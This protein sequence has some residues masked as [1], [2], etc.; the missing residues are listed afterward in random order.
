[1]EP[2]VRRPHRHDLLIAAAGLVGG[3]S[4]WL[5]GLRMQNGRPF[6][7][8]WAGL[9]PLA[10]MAAAELMRCTRPGAA[11]ALATVL[12]AADQ[13]TPGNMA[14]VLMYTDVVYAAV[15]YGSE[16]AARRIPVA[17]LLGSVALALALLPRLRPA[18]AVLVGVL[19]GLVSFVPAITG[20]AARNHRDAAEAARLRAE[21][22]ALLAETDRAQ[23]V[24]EERSRM[25]RELH[26]VVAGHLSAIALHSTAALSIDDPPTS[27]EALSVIRENSVAGLAEMRRLIGLL[28]EGGAPDLPGAAPRLSA[29]DALIERSRAHAASSGLTCVLDDARGGGVLPAPVELA[30]YR[31]VQESL[32]NALKHAAPGAVR[33]RLARPGGLLTVEVTSVSG[34][35]KGFRTPGSGAGLIGMRERAELLGGTIRAGEERAADGTALWRVRAELPVPDDV[36]GHGETTS[37]DM[38]KGR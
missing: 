6:E 27:R 29:L 9:V 2:V 17:S 22:T 23:A 35:R 12:L 14:T 16:A 11:L 34:A 20:A 33:V 28:R 5:L 10:P 37:E 13:F 18:D 30:A 24:A 31:I 25:A 26:D 19:A 32:T 36:R 15:V 21:R 4:L 7:A 3:L 38:G 1:M 8:P